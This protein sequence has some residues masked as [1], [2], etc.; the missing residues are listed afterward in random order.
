VKVGDLV[1]LK[2]Y[3]TAPIGLSGELR[4]W[5]LAKFRASIGLIVSIDH[6]PRNA[7]PVKVQWLDGNYDEYRNMNELEVVSD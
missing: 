7:A 5:W 4:D 2:D 6:H 1:R 3:T